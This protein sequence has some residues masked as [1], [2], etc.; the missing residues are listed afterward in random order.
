MRSDRA[1]NPAE[2]SSVI[3]AG[4]T[5]S[6]R[7][8]HCYTEHRTPNNRACGRS[9]APRRVQTSLATPAS[10]N[11]PAPAAIDQI[12]QACNVALTVL[13]RRETSVYLDQSFS[14]VSTASISRAPDRRQI[15]VCKF[16]DWLG[17]R[18][19]AVV[20]RHATVPCSASDHARNGLNRRRAYGQTTCSTDR[21]LEFDDRR[22]ACL[23]TLP[24]GPGIVR[25]VIRVDRSRANWCLAPVP[26]PHFMPAVSVACRSGREHAL[27]M[28]SPNSISSTA[29][30]A[31][32]Y[33]SPMDS[34]ESATDKKRSLRKLDDLKRCEPPD[35]AIT[36]ADVELRS[37]CPWRH[38]QPRIAVVL[39]MP[40]ECDD[41]HTCRLTAS[42]S[43]APDRRQICVCKFDDWLGRRLHAVVRRRPRRH[44]I[45]AF[46]RTCIELWILSIRINK[47]PRGEIL[48]EHT[49][50]I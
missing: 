41:T 35:R 17:R 50:K 44:F 2:R 18:L 5:P 32:R 42:I 14:T 11:P 7:S 47:D 6:H 24:R 29:A 40:R 4:R 22:L 37:E 38:M 9:D 39:P 21:A 20:R 12:G 48:G 16:D 8:H 45:R 34:R 27:Q 3:P 19:H 31:K 43:R 46:V 49:G 30:A 28:A 15:C 26:R 33:E 23:D 1:S 13:H 25:S 10:Q 36:I